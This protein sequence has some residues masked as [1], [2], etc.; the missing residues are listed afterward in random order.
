MPDD[1][2]TFRRQ[3]AEALAREPS[4]AE[5]EVDLAA[6]ILRWLRT[7]DDRLLQPEIWPFVP[8]NEPTALG[9]EP[10]CTESQVSPPAGD[11]DRD[12]SSDARGEEPGRRG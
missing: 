8:T 10:K 3:V 5:L 7:P 11:H 1:D 2:E 4:R 6:R 12:R 9:H